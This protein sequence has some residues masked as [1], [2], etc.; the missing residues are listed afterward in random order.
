MNAL[1]LK[2]IAGL[3]FVLAVLAGLLFIPAQTLD[4][5]Q[6]WVF[7]SVYF[8]ASL[9][10]TLYLMKHDR[11]LLERRISGGPVAEK[12]P[13]QKIIMLITSAGFIGLVLV[14]AIDRQEGWSSMPGWVALLGDLLMILGWIAI[15]FV[16]REN[17]FSSATIELAP[18]HKVISSGP[19]ALVRHPMYA[20]G[21]LLVMGLPLALL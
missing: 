11:K 10:I 18:D 6:A 20:G 16:F 17:T 15:F 12:E 2:A 9:A 3:V 5:W 21:V 13:V 19:Y 1:D 7:L 4:Y 8:I 14:P